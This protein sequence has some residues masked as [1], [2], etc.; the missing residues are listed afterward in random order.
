VNNSELFLLSLINQNPRYGY[1]IA[2]FLEESNAGLWINISMPY[3]Y[4]LLKSFEE[5]GLV[6]TQV[7]V[8][9]NR[10]NRTMYQI[11]A[12]GHA[13]LLNNLK[14]GQFIEDKIYFSSDLALAIS[15][16]TNI[17][18]NL[19]HLIADQIERVKAE[20][21]QFDLQ[22]MEEPEVAPDVK[23]AHLIIEHRVVFLKAELEWLKKVQET[24]GE[25]RA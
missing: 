25:V 21:D 15:A 16:I 8:S 10:P 4:K 11:T 6:S 12:E 2:Q 19:P 13:A 5:R 24:I 22:V 17:D 23:M 20:L 1:E 9:K 18:F 14:K 3:V 7:V